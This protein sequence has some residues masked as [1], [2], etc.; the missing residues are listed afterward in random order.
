MASVLNRE[1]KVI[2]E[3][4][5]LRFSPLFSSSSRAFYETQSNS[6]LPKSAFHWIAASGDFSALFYDF[7]IVWCAAFKARIKS[8]EIRKSSSQE[9]N[10]N[11]TVSPKGNPSKVT[12]FQ[13]LIFCP[14]IHFG[15]NLDF[16]TYKT[17]HFLGLEWVSTIFWTKTGVLA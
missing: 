11:L 7:C 8:Q 5:S 6:A 16:L 15:Q 14:I 10:V 17:S 9:K 1:R 2:I 3:V 12:L 13:K 4:A